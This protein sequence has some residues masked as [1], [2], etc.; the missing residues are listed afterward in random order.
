MNYLKGN[1]VQVSLECHET[2]PRLGL[3]VG[4]GALTEMTAELGP[5]GWSGRAGRKE[6]TAD[7]YKQRQKT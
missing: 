7:R 4:L 6:D 3:P 1:T 5:E 2:F